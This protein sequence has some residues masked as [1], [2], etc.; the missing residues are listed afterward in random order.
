LAQRNAVAF[1][2]PTAL[3]TNPSNWSLEIMAAQDSSGRNPSSN[4]RDA[5]D[6]ELAMLGLAPTT[7]AHQERITLIIPV[8]NNRR[9]ELDLPPEV[10]GWLRD[11]LTD[12]LGEQKRKSRRPVRLKKGKW[13][14]HSGGVS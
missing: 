11:Q 12:A 8:W 3:L 13:I 7:T 10:A 2:S 14:D 4:P 9:F 5:I 1:G 6:F